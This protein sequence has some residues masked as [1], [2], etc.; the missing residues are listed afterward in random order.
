VLDEEW[1]CALLLRGSS[2]RLAKNSQ[3]GYSSS[4]RLLNNSFLL[5]LGIN[6]REKKY[7]KEVKT[8]QTTGVVET[9]TTKTPGI[10]SDTSKIG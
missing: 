2:R 10:I 8:L 3:N 6:S 7:V 1:I 9:T 5:R 4:V